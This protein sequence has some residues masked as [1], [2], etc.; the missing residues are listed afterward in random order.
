MNNKQHPNT[1]RLCELL[2][3]EQCDHYFKMALFSD[4]VQVRLTQRLKVQGAISLA[5]EISEA[6]GIIAAQLYEAIQEQI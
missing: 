5:N 6:S 1:E 2:V 3:D 4:K